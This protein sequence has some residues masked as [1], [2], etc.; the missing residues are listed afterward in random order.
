MKYDIDGLKAKYD[1]N[2]RLKYL[3]FWGHQPAR[4]GSTRKSCLSQWWEQEFTVENIVYQTAEHW[5]MAQKALLFGDEEIHGKILLAK[6]PGEAKDLG[7]RVRNFDQQVWADH[8]CAIV[9]AGNYHKFS[10][11]DALR[12][13]LLG[14]QSRILVEAS[15]VDRIWGIGLTGDQPEAQNPYTWQGLN[16]LGFAQMEVRD[17]LREVE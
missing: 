10:Q 15:P 16:L 13:F 3:F 6:T 9:V 8:R 7:R 2:E 1:Q 11:D 4:D 17:K 14:T 12:E 5:M